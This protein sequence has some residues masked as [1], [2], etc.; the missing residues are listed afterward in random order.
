MASAGDEGTGSEATEPPGQAECAGEPGHM[1]EGHWHWPT[2]P[3]VKW[4]NV[5]LQ[6]GGS[7]GAFTWGVLDRLLE[8]ERLA[9]ESIS[10][11]SAGA[12]NA[13]VMAEGLHHGGPREARRRLEA[14][15]RSI[16]LGAHNPLQQTMFDIVLSNWSLE[17]NPFLA[18]FE[19]MSRVVSPYQFNPLNLNP[20]KELLEER[21]DFAEVQACQATELYISATNVQTGRVRVFTGEEVTADA[22]MASACLPYIFQAVEIDGVPYWDGG[23]MGNP[24]LFPFLDCSV[25]QDVLIVQVNPIHRAKT[26]TS[27][28]EIADRISEISFNAPLIKE[29][30]HID[31]INRAVQSGDLSQQGYRE[32]FLHRIGGGEEIARYSASTKLNAEWSFLRELRDAGR[33]TAARW[34]EANFDSIGSK[35]TMKTTPYLEF[36]LPAEPLKRRDE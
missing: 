28:R 27:A 1:G 18:M 2:G 6:G 3:E 25:S 11:T 36:A 7:H 35:S 5:A 31:F 13:V 30:R 23:F 4:I 9:I 12:V 29:L 20:L 33:A 17:S 21:I 22:V 24:V 19:M 14:F 8:E 32:V 15:W 34:I 16:A 26:P 10:G